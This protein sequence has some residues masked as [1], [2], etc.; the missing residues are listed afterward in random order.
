MKETFDF[1]E[2]QLEKNNK[3]VLLTV[4]NWYGSSPGK[5]GFKL[6]VS[7]NGS[8]FGSIGGGAMEHRLVEKMKKKLNSSEEFYPE[9][10]Y[11]NHDPDAKDNKSGMICSGNQTIAFI[12]LH[13]KDLHEVRLM[14]SIINNKEKGIWVINP[15]GM[16]IVPNKVLGKR[17][18]TKIKSEKIWEYAEQLGMPDT[19]FIFGG[20]H[21]G[22]ALSKVFYNLNFRVVIL[23]NRKDLNTMK[24]NHFAD[25]KIVIDY[26]DS[27]KY[28]TNG[29]NIYVA[30]VTFAHKSDAQVLKQMINK[31]IKYLGMMGSAK[32]I[33]TIYDNLIKEGIS[34]SSL[35]KVFAPIGV[36]INSE[37]PDEIA[38]SIAAQIIKVKND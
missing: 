35:A 5:T 21:V 27:G 10:K 14:L 32:K 12:P 4:I 19:L 37:T 24:A 33:E 7:S 22:L 9:I 23:D 34:T 6:A 30:V 29:F 8:F 16:S 11:Y 25:E 20:G 17:K 1:I 3:I 38:I 2:K 15:N 13:K 26:A 31:D 18:I 36:P 28:V